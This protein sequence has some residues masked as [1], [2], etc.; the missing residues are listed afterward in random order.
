VNGNISLDPVFCDAPRGDLH[1]RDDSPCDAD[2]N[3]SCGLIGALPVGCLIA[4]A[5]DGIDAGSGLSIG[6]CVPNPFRGTTTV[7]F[8][9]PSATENGIAALEIFDVAGRR[10]RGL[11]QEAARPGR[12]EATWDG[13]NDAG[14]AVRAGT[15]FCRVRCGGEVRTT[16]V[17]L[18][19]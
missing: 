10:V 6:P 11:V 3:T 16:R 4:G 15:Y 2:Y 18:V 12:Y 9:I 14:E 19:R 5:D 13:R 8:V 17:V 1:I 7:A